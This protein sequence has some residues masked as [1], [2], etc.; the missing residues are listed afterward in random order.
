MDNTLVFFNINVSFWLDCVHLNFFKTSPIPKIFKTQKVAF[1]RTFGGGSIFNVWKPVFFLSQAVSDGHELISSNHV[2]WAGRSDR[3]RSPKKWILEAS[4]ES[5]VNLIR[6]LIRCQPLRFTG[7]FH[8][9]SKTFGVEKRDT[10]VV[11]RQP[12]LT[13]RTIS[14]LSQ[15]K[16][17]V[18]LT[19]LEAKRVGG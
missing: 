11:I 8:L 4:V 18:V 15:C 9:V 3:A 17:Q 14:D 7:R 19:E 10:G 2:T 12:T 16:K 1:T 13:N 6:E 5:R